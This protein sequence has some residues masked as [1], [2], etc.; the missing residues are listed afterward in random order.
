MEDL[1]IDFL[2]EELNFDCKLEFG[3][4]EHTALY[5][6]KQLCYD[7]QRNNVSIKCKSSYSLFLYAFLN[8]MGG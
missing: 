2:T 8:S 4:F 3:K 6:P 1:N 5:W 7:R